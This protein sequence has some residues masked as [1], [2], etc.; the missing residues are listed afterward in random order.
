MSS[1][2]ACRRKVLQKIGRCLA[3]APK[4]VYNFP[5]QTQQSM[6]T[7]F[8]DS[9]WAGCVKMV[10]SMSGGGLT[11]SYNLLK[12]YNMQQRVVALS[13][14]EAELYAMVAASVETIAITAYTLATSP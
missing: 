1:P 4:L 14:A 6:V 11:V 3:C 7:T 8:T 10:R 2:R 9:D 13:S 12:T 5:L